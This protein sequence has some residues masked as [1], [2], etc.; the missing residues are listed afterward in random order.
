MKSITTI[1]IGAGQA[2]LAAS[3]ELTRRGVDHLILDRG[4]VGNAW[5]TARWDSLRLLTPNWANGMPGAPYQGADTNGYMSVGEFAIRLQKYAWQIDAP[6]QDDTDVQR[7]RAVDGG[8]VIKTDREMFRCKALVLAS[9]ACARPRVP[10]IASSIPSHI[11][12]TTPSEYKRAD[13]LPDGPA[14]VVG[15]SASGVQI[16][17]EIQSSGRQVTL[18][19][20]W[21]TRLP[22]LYRGRDIEWWLDA[23]GVLDEMLDEVDDINRVRRTPSPQLIGGSDPVDLNALQ[24]LGVEI[25]G[26]LADVRDGLAMFSGG[27]A[28]ACMSADLKMN[29][30][31][32]AVDEWIDQRSL[33]EALPPPHRPAFTRTPFEP[34]LSRSLVDGGIRSIIWATGYQPDF[35]WLEVPVFDHRGALQHHGGVVASPGL[36]ALGLMFMRK[37][38]SQQISGV[39][40]DA[41][42]ISSHLRRYLDGRSGVAA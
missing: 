20:G 39:G 32:D 10:V 14:L 2:G 38:R 25:V 12:Q 41:E 22:R 31:L 24:E 16:A 3:R 30:F 33:A 1:I 37:R 35:S 27:L 18:A 6:I 13:D 11:F 8:Y 5:R 19:A 28:N 21:H 23:L 26:R 17:R 15:A 40:D 34:S 4:G 29:R 7:V 42:H 9:G 36:Y